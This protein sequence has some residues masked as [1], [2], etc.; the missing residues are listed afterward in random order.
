MTTI[1]PSIPTAWYGN[2]WSQLVLGVIAMMAISSPQ[3]FWTLFSR[4]LNQK[5]RTTR[6]ELQ[7]TFSLLII[8]QTWCS[9]LQ[10]H[11]VDKFGPRLLISVGALMAGGGWGLSSY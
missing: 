9:P 2:R 10:A 3:Y 7:W 5:L 8:L 11:L 6:A 4:T 1:A